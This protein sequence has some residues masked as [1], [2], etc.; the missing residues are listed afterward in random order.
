MPSD[1]SLPPNAPA[2]LTNGSIPDPSHPPPVSSTQ[3][4]DASRSADGEA[5]AYL[6][7]EHDDEIEIPP[8]PTPL[9]E[10][11][12]DVHARVTAFLESPSQDETVKRTQEQARLSIGVIEEALKEYGYVAPIRHN[13]PRRR[14]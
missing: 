2:T 8:N 6:H 11:C 14:T 7:S 1:A 12:A 13:A 10:V 5:D 4:K 9:S 3:T